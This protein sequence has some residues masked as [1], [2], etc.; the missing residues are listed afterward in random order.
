MVV[1]KGGLVSCVLFGLLGLLATTSAASAQGMDVTVFTGLA[2]PLY[3]QRLTLRPGD[4]SIPGVE[5][6]SASSPVLRGD[7]GPVLGA[8]LA[9]E[10]GILGIEG[11][12]DTMDTAI[13]FSGARYDLRGTA[14]PFQGVTASIIASPGRF[15]ADRISVLSLN[16]R[17]RTPGPIG[18]VVSGG[19]S[20]LPD[21]TVSGSVPLDVESPQL[22]PLGF[23]AGLTL[24]ATPGQSGH[25]LGVNGGAGLRIGGR[26]ALVAE[27]RAFYF[28]EYALRFGTANGPQL[29]DDLLAEADPVNFEPVFVNAQVGLAFRF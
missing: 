5:V 27:A 7:G 9:V 19:V 25:R 14:F 12:L 18:L 26:I 13:D 2:Y 15:E 11:R 10:F 28:R 20:Y 24:R 16:A 8:A 23:D 29:L 1:R 3:D 22:P 6:T 21:I 17:I 4:P